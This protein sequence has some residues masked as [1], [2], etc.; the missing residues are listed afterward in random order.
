MTVSVLLAV[1]GNIALWYF[2][3]GVN[4]QIS[5]VVF[6]LVWLNLVLGIFTHRRQP[7]LSYILLGAVYVLEL[8]LAVN[9]FWIVGRVM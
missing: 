2:G 3:K 1:L 5:I 7:N 4:F 8:F 6:L 9:L